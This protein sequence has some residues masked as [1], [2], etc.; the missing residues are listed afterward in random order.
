MRVGGDQTCLAL[1]RIYVGLFGFS[2]LCLDDEV[3]PS[4][5]VRDA[6]A[7]F[8]RAV[9]SVLSSLDTFP[10]ALTLVFKDYLDKRHL[11][12]RFYALAGKTK[13]SDAFFKTKKI[14]ITSYNIYTL[15]GSTEHTNL[16]RWTS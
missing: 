12:E 13:T 3:T 5:E 9:F 6:G 7:E 16:A 14:F 11:W 10:R 2:D 1:I 4:A 15:G 8:V